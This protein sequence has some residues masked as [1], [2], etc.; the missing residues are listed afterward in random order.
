M[1]RKKLDR[2][3]ENPSTDEAWNLTRQIGKAMRVVG[4]QLPFSAAQRRS[5]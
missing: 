5:N 1:S 3:I 2:A 4:R